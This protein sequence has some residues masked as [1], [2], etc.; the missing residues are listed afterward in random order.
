MFRIPEY[1]QMQCSIGFQQKKPSG[2]YGLT[3]GLTGLF[4]D[5]GPGCDGWNP[6]FLNFPGGIFHKFGIKIRKHHSDTQKIL[7][8]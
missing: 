5:H 3:T 8:A 1:D 6:D 7:L 2:G 4:M